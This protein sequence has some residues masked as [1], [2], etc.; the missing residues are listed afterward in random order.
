MNQYKLEA[1]EAIYK[2]LCVKLVNKK[3][4]AL[5]LEKFIE[6]FNLTKKPIGQ[7]GQP[8]IATIYI[9]DT[10]GKKES[11]SAVS[12]LNNVKNEIE[13]LEMQIGAINVLISELQRE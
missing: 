7:N 4:E 2:N 13:E 8:N 9:T 5:W 11:K 1:A 12:H 3:F 6:N 10:T